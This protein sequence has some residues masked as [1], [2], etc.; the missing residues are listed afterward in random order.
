MKKEFTIL[1]LI[2]SSA[3][4]A[5]DLFPGNEQFTKKDTLRGTLSPLRTCFDV[6]FYDLNI[7][8]PKP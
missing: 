5:Q 2:I 3:L 7:K 4:F 8:I 1:F 6:G